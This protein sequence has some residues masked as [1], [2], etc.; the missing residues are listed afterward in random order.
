MHE[1]ASFQNRANTQMNEIVNRFLNYKREELKLE[2][3][4]ERD[5]FDYTVEE[6]NQLNEEVQEII[7]NMLEYD[8]YE[9]DEDI[10]DEDDDSIYSDEDTF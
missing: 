3:S 1:F 9:C 10:T 2:L 5:D 4:A 7:E 8:N 6:M